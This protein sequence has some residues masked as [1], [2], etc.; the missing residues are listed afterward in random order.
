MERM[1]RIDFWRG[2]L[3]AVAEP[4]CCPDGQDYKSK[5]R[6]ARKRGKE[7]DPRVNYE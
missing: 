3:S 2:N 4:P 5:L 7:K 1:A 6:K